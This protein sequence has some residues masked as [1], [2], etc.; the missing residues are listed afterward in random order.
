[1]KKHS[2]SLLSKFIGF[3]ANKTGGKIYRDATR[4]F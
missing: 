3:A 2:L 1:M 4:A